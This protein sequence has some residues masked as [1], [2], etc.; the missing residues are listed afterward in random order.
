MFS[1]SFTLF[2]SSVN[3]GD[4]VVCHEIKGFRGGKMPARVVEGHRPAQ[5]GMAWV[6]EVRGLENRPK[7][8]EPF[9][10]EWPVSKLA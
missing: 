7:G 5:E 1:S 2:R 6:E 8:W 3:L 4:L 10:T 9:F